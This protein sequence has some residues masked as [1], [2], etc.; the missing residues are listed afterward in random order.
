MKFWKKFVEKYKKKIE[1]LKACFYVL[2]I[3]VIIGSLID[4]I[5]TFLAITQYGALEM[6]PFAA[7]LMNLVGVGPAVVIGFFATILPLI[8]IHYG[9][10][11][12]KWD[13]L[14]H[15]WIYTLFMTIYFSI[16][17][18]LVEQELIWWSLLTA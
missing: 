14:V 11:R 12:F 13:K 16:W 5:F 9:I 8:L 10:R 4:K 18:E 1:R 7:E 2:E 17:F 15:Y 3:G 6:N